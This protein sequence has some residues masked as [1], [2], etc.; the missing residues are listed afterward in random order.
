MISQIGFMQGRLSP[1]VNGRIQSFPWN[2]WQNE[3]IESKEIGFSLMEWTL[4]E[5]GLYKNPLMTSEGQNEILNLCNEYDFHIESLTGD[6][7]MQAPFWKAQGKS[8]IKHLQKDFLNVLE[9][10]NKVGIKMVVVPLVD[11]GS[12]SELEQE[13]CLVE[14]LLKHEEK[15]ENLNIKVIFESDFNPANLSRFISRLSNENF[16]INYDIGN[17]AAL[18]LNP[19]EEFNVIGNRILNVHV[20]DRPLAGTTVP[21]G[22]GN[23][24]FPL[25]FDLLNKH[26]YSRNYI[27]Q[28]A[29]AI[30]ENHASALSNYKDMVRDW[31]AKNES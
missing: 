8:E 13:N 9:A 28:T 26:N 27:L 15:I 18:G 11:N 25:V 30:D 2:N 21:L 5:D 31:L 7:F 12:L 20:K 6:C 14:F 1:V 3:I 29:R 16:G 24:N 4:D 17:S 19:I 10:C 23:V 22:Q